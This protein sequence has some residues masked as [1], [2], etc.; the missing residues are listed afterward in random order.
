MDDETKV[1]PDCAETVLAGASVCRFCGHRFPTTRTIADGVFRLVAL[2]FAL[3]VL[4][5]AIV[6]LVGAGR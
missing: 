2:G 5:V 1:C 6:I 3:L 4:G